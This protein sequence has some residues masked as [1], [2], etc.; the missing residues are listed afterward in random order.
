MAVIRALM[1][2]FGRLGRAWP[3]VLV[4]WLVN[5]AVAAPFAVALAADLDHDLGKS[6][7]H[8][9]L[10]DGFDM[11]WQGELQEGARGIVTTF[12]PE[13][14]RGGAFFENL[15]RWWQGDLLSL[16][17][18]LVAAGIAYAALWAFL[19]GGVIERLGAGPHGAGAPGA[20]GFFGACGRHFFRFLRLALLSG[21]LY[22]LVYRLLRAGFGWLSDDAMRD[23]TA[24]RTALGWTFVALALAVLLLTLVRV[25]FDYAKIAVVAEGRRSALGAAWRGARFVA[26][27]PVATLGLYGV[28]TFAGLL[29][30]ALYAGVAP[31]PGQGT[32][33]G[34]ILAFLVGQL[35]LATKIALRLALLGSE[36]SLFRHPNDGF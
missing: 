23:V 5:V 22:Y 13:L 20:A 26:A 7:V 4:L 16:P 34:V 30:L 6:L 10:L 15:E 32:W 31:G 12:G 19:L 1:N 21:V 18:L 25:V 28:V 8:E 27:R 11:G 36:A 2:G 3:L 17:P 14:L 29:L 24:E 33:I 9:N 35:A